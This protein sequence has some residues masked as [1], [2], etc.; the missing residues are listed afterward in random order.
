MRKEY[1]LIPSKIFLKDLEKL[2]PNIKPK[3]DKALLELKI[4][5]H[6][7]PNIKKLRNVEIGQWRLRIGDW[8]LRYDIAGNKIYLHI[9]RQRKDVYRK[10]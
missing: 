5:P 1:K 8:R 10:K 4:D 3:V 9:I 6:S 2:P 7:S